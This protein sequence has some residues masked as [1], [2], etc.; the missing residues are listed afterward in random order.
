MEEQEAVTVGVRLVW[1]QG[2]KGEGVLFDPWDSRGGV[3]EA[4]A[5]GSRVRKEEQGH[6]GPMVLV[7]RHH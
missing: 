3:P 1:F 7:F 6:H 4:P 2:A 5:W